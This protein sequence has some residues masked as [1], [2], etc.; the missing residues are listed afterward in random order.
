MSG[1]LKYAISLIKSGD[2]EAGKEEL[3]KIL[4]EDEKNDRAWVWMSAVVETDELRLDCLEE[5]LA[6]NPDN[7]AALKGVEKLRE[8]LGKT[9]VPLPAPQNDDHDDDW[10]TPYVEPLPI[11]QPTRAPV[12]ETYSYDKFAPPLEPAAPKKDPAKHKHHVLN[13]SPFLTI[14][15]M[16]R[17]TLRAILLTDPGKYVLLLAALPGLIGGVI[18]A[19][20]T[21]APS[22]VKM[23]TLLF[24]FIFGPV[25]GIVVLY[26]WGALFSWL[27][28]FLGGKGTAQE[29]RAAFAWGYVPQIVLVLPL[30]G[31]QLLAFSSFMPRMAAGMEPSSALVA[32]SGLLSCLLLPASIYAFII[33]LQC[34]G[35]AHQ[36]SAWRAW[37]TLLLPSLLFGCAICF[38]SFVSGLGMAY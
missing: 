15:Y 17:P 7:A 31:L 16:P 23:I 2:K 28:F 6:I 18:G 11:I 14:W 36:F 21:P 27:G 19:L 26:I 37:G 25:M 3:L 13:H 34:L 9:A 33:M 4:Q 10:S 12:Q 35:E 22:A 1:D 5:A 29:V 20:I 30:A 32:F 8:K 38:A 24:S